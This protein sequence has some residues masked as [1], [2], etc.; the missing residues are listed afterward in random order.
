MSGI[1]L[2]VQISESSRRGSGVRHRCQAQVSGTGTVDVSS[3]Q[4]LETVHKVEIKY[5]KGTSVR[6]IAY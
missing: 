3:I 5:I 2:L 1:L 4:M 6:H